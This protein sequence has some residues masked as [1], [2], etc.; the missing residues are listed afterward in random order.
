MRGITL[1]SASGLAIALFAAPAGAQDAARPGRDAPAQTTQDQATRPEAGDFD[2]ADVIVTARRREERLR[3]VPV[4]ATVVD[5]QSIADRGGVNTVQEILQNAPGVRFFNTSSQ[6]NSETSIRGSGTARGTNADPSV[7][8]Y[9]NGVYVGGGYLGGRNFAR[10]DFFDIGRAEV[11]RGTQGA[12]YG[13][14]AVGGA[15]NFVSAEPAFRNEGYLDVNYGFETD[16]LQ[17][18]GVGNVQL[19]DK[20]AIRIGGERAYQW[21]GFFYNPNNDVYYDRIDSTILR[22]QFRYKSGIADVNYMVEH[23]EADVPSVTFRV[24]IRPGATAAFPLGYVQD[25]YVYPWNFPPR[26]TQGIDTQILSANLDLGFATLT[27]TSAYRQRR[28]YFQFDQDGIDAAALAA[29]NAQGQNR[30]A[31]PNLSASNRDLTRTWSQD[32]HLSG[33]KVAGFT[34]LLGVEYID[35]RTDYEILSGTTATEPIAGNRTNGRQTYKSVAGYG[36][37]GYDLTSWLNLT[38]ELRYT[39]DDKSIVSRQVNR[40]TGAPGGAQF[41]LNGAFSPTNLAYTAIAAIKPTT[42]QLLYAKVGSGYRAGGF[43]Y[44]LGDPRQPIPIPAFYGNE[45]STTYELGYKGNPARWLFVTAAAYRTDT[46]NVV[47][48]TQNGCAAGNPVCPVGSTPFLTNAGTARSWG[49]ELEAT[50]SFRMAGGRTR[51]TLSG[52]RQDG[53]IRSGPLRGAELPQ[54]PDWIASAQLNYRVPVAPKASA[55][56]NLNYQGA[57]GGV[58]ELAPAGT[59]FYQTA[60][61]GPFQAPIDDISLLD[62]RAGVQLG[63]VE[64]SVYARNAAQYRYIVYEAITTQRL[65]PRRLIGVQTRIRF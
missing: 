56:F 31:N 10:A 14:N 9:R 42:N 57:F 40:V 12:L 61:Q 23:Q 7:G 18:Q 45:T 62:L 33:N 29:L 13:R 3:D 20:V 43:N 44:N 41:N 39:S 26:A 5:A 17:V 27:S 16:F 58:N 51:I 36:S 28:A 34:W 11:L 38:G 22:G 30:G 21:K 2:P 47:I 50:A 59:P 37:L 4:A 52:S 46:N 53:E 55:F 35:Q 48:G 54:T 1:A 60:A 19:G 49:V 64:L 65:N 8:L 32:L 24:A 63:Q 15:V 6:V 25:P